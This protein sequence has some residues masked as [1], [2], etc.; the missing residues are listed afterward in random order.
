MNL[1]SKRNQ[2]HAICTNYDKCKSLLKIVE[3]SSDV[4][5]SIRIRSYAY[6]EVIDL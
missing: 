1:G 3:L 6:H 5:S 4:R 2:T